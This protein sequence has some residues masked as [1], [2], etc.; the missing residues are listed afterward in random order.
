MFKEVIYEDVASNP[1]D[2]AEDMYRF[3][4]SESVP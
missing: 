2:M 3:S 4:F 1:L